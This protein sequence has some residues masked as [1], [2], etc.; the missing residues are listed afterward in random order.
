MNETN[1]SKSKPLYDYKIIRIRS[2]EELQMIR[3]IIK[4]KIYNTFVKNVY[5]NKLMTKD[6]SDSD[7]IILILDMTIEKQKNIKIYFTVPNFEKNEEIL[8]FSEYCRGKNIDP[9]EMD[10]DDI[11]ML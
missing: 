10:I 6:L 2:E 3:M 9:K 11:I 7:N 1:T 4:N 8:F 5:F